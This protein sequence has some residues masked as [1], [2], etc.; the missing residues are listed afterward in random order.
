MHVREIIA[1]RN[2]HVPSPASFG[3]GASLYFL[4]A[5][6]APT[7]S[8]ELLLLSDQYWHDNDANGALK[9][10]CLVKKIQE[11]TISSKCHRAGPNLVVNQRHSVLYNLPLRQLALQD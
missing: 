3:V 6:T 11:D 8:I 2:M 9:T 1:L 4:R 10:A 7:A 5:P